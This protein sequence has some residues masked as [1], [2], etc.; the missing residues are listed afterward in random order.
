LLMNRAQS[1]IELLIID[2]PSGLDEQGIEQLIEI[3]GVLSQ[4]FKQILV[5]SHLSELAGAFPNTIF[6]NKKLSGSE[7]LVQ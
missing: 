4:D 6:V 3:L 1:K 5:I 7:V 2:E